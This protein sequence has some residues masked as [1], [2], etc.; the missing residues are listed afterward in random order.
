[1]LRDVILDAYARLF[2]RPGLA[3]WN[4]FLHQLSLRGLG[5]LNYRSDALSGELPFAKRLLP[6]LDGADSVVLDIGGNEGAFTALALAS[7]RQARVIAFEP[8]PGTHARLAARF[9][10]EPRVGVVN[11]AVGADAGTLRLYDY[12][13]GDG[14]GHATLLAGVIDRPGG[15]EARAHDVTVTTLDAHPLPGRVR[16][17]KIDVEGY[18]LAVLQGARRVLAEHR[19]D[20]V[21]LE[22][23]EMN[24]T[25]KT[26]FTDVAAALPGYR[27]YRLLPAGRLLRLGHPYHALSHEIFAYQNLVFLSSDTDAQ[28]RVH[29]R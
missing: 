22:F 1:M 12:P 25:A 3:K 17:V 20:V 6:T 27:A 19:P 14:S 7:T 15:G 28:G 10:G 2:A 21:L 5:V 4:R 11:A 16:F 26:F 18:E 9:G 24:A 8:H 29:S 13:D 23:N